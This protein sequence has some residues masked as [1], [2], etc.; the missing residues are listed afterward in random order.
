MPNTTIKAIFL[1]IF[2]MHTSLAPHTACVELLVFGVKAKACIVC[3]KFGRS[4]WRMKRC[5]GRA[6]AFSRHP[7]QYLYRP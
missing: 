1:V 5:Q 6:Y 7:E 3:C 2:A 4:E